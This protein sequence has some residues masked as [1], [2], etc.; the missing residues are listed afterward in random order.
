MKKILLLCCLLLSS[1]SSMKPEE[2]RNANWRDIGYNDAMQGRTVLLKNHTQ[3]CSKINLTPNKKAYLA[4]HQAGSKKFCTY[5]NG[6][7]FGRRGNDTSNICITPELTK[8]FYGGYKDGLE[9]YRR[10]LYLRERMFEMRERFHH[11]RHKHKHKNKNKDN[12]KH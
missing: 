3:A 8:P 2:C 12:H 11:N 6:F 9:V 7:I 1:C 10:E 4:G 5:K